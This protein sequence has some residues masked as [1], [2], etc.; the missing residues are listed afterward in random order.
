MNVSL[1]APALLVSVAVAFAATACARAQETAVA[2][3]AFDAR[4]DRQNSESRPFVPSPA[5]AGEA[6]RADAPGADAGPPDIS[7]GDGPADPKSETPPDS[8]DAA[9]MADVGG[10]ADGPGGETVSCGPAGAVCDTEK[11]CSTCA[12]GIRRTCYC[13]ELDAGPR[14]WVCIPERDEC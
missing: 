2:D 12:G 5:D 11:T 8:K 13:V 9:P 1:S 4:Q 7:A 6:D 14:Q 3:G 10:S